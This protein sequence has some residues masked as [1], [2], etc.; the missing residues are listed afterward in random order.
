[1]KKLEH[2]LEIDAVDWLQTVG[3]S[4]LRPKRLIEVVIHVPVEHVLIPPGAA[5]PR[6]L[7]GCPDC[8]APGWEPLLPPAR[9][10]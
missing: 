8:G 3:E 6:L 7:G 5:P 4:A 10:L 9:L 1:M 2:V